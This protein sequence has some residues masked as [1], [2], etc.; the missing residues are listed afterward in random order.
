MPKP[1]HA[2]LTLTPT[3]EGLG[4]GTFKPLTI[5][6]L[7]GNNFSATG[8]VLVNGKWINIPGYIPPASTAAQAA[9]TSL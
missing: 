5:P 7:A 9:R 3:V 8:K 1:V 2:A 6:S 4:G